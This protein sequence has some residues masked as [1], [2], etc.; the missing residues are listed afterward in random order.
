MI[1]KQ[2]FEVVKIVCH[3]KAQNDF[4]N[5]NPKGHVVQI[6][7]PQPTLRTE[8]DIGSE[9]PETTAVS[10]FFRTIFRS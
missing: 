2:R 9:N 5:H 1:F 8:K 3:S 4:G 10:G 7:S 6:P